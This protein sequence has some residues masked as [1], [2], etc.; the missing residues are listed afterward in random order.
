MSKYIRIF[1]IYLFILF[2]P[3]L[4]IAGENLTVT[5]NPNPLFSLTN[6]AP[7]DSLKGLVKVENHSGQT[8]KIDVEAI[9]VLDA[10]NLSN[11]FNLQIK[12]GVDILFENSLNIFLESG[13]I[14]L[15]GLESGSNNI[16]EFII[17]FDNQA[18]N[19]LQGK[20]LENFDLLIGFL[21][22]EKIPVIQSSNSNPGS[23]SNSSGG[24]GGVF[25][26]LQNEPDIVNNEPN[27][28]IKKIKNIIEQIFI[29]AEVDEVNS[30]QL[31]STV[32]TGSRQASAGQV[33]GEQI[34]STDSTSSQQVNSEQTEE[35]DKAITVQDNIQ[36][37]KSFPLFAVVIIFFLILILIIFIL[38]F[39]H[40]NGKIRV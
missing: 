5:F 3:L 38:T 37:K 25:Q 31:H 18:Q 22:E 32:P 15:S 24:A 17:T 20:T 29:P 12:Q 8:K 35:I 33:A 11:V 30:E 27:F 21:G 14:V 40:K 16:Y 10:E 26:D 2:S 6:F 28:I 7:G 19:E 9:N 23:G 13:E 36:N 4:V 39:K 34:H 1:L